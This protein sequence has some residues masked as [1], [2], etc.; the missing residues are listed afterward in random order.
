MDQPFVEAADF[1]DFYVESWPMFIFAASRCIAHNALP[2]SYHVRAPATGHHQPTVPESWPRTSE[3][4]PFTQREKENEPEE[5]TD[6]DP[7]SEPEEV[8]ASA[9][10]QFEPSVAWYRE[11]GE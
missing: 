3:Y 6:S 10:S 2:S 9:G 11:S 4:A 1:D 7:L 5:L 8:S